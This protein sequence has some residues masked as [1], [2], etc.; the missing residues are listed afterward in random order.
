MSQNLQQLLHKVDE[1]S[2]HDTATLK[3]L[4]FVRESGDFDHFL[5]SP[6][7]QQAF[8]AMQNDKKHCSILYLMPDLQEGSNDSEFTVAVS[9]I[10]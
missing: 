2:P 7:T 6:K 10:Q 1:V 8:T 9:Q 5:L 4:I 3:I